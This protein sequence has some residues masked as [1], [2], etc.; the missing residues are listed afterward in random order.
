MDLESR[1]VLDSNHIPAENR[2]E[3]AHNIRVDWGMAH[4]KSWWAVAHSGL[5]NYHHIE[6]H[7][8][9]EEVEP[10]QTGVGG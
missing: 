8:Y 5:N 3:V 6:G 9:I 4:D 1:A 7:N 10:P 2:P